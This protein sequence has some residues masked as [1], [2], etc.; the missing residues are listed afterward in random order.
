MGQTMNA[1]SISL[2]CGGDFTWSIGVVGSLGLISPAAHLL[3]SIFPGFQA[4]SQSLPY[5]L[6][7]SGFALNTAFFLLCPQTISLSKIAS[8]LGIPASAALSLLAHVLASD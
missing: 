6:Y 2:L 7:T 8:A 5:C 4:L 1:I 3:Q